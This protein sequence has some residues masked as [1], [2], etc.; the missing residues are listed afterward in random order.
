MSSV[1]VIHLINIKVKKIDPLVFGLEAN[2]PIHRDGSFTSASFSNWLLRVNFY[3]EF[4]IWLADILIYNTSIFS[5]TILIFIS[6]G[7]RFWRLLFTIFYQVWFDRHSPN[8]FHLSIYVINECPLKN[9]VKSDWGMAKAK[10][11]CG[12]K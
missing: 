11:V 1:F 12:K 5:L 9:T 10:H 2:I 6:V 3:W 7:N 8:H 4:K